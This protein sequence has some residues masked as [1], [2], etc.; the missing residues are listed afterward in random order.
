MKTKLIGLTDLIDQDVVVR[1]NRKP[2]D[3]HPLEGFVLGVSGKLLLLHLVDGN[4]LLLSG[5]AVVN[6]SDIRSYRIDTTFVTRALRLLART[7]AAP[8]GVDLTDWE[9][10]F[11]SLKNCCPLLMLEMERKRPGAGFVGQV[12]R[13]TPRNVVVEQVNPRGKWT[14]TKRFAYKDITQVTFDNGYV[15]ALAQLVEYEA[16][17]D[18]LE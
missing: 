6:L 11:G 15:N 8:E 9:S 12:A 18:L 2:L 10:V 5:Y 14:K 1:I 16:T 3:K 4:T 17:A 13:Q 7:P